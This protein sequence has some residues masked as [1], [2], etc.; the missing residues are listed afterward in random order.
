[1]TGNYPAERF[2]THQGT[3]DRTRLPVLEC[4][5]NPASRKLA[6]SSRIFLDIAFPRL[7]IIGTDRRDERGDARSVGLVF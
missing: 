6:L 3:C 1:M 5:R 7:L 2:L 4:T